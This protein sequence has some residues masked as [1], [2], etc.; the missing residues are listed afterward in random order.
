MVTDL[1]LDLIPYG[2]CPV[3]PATLYF[4][5]HFDMLDGNTAW[6]LPCP[7]TSDSLEGN[8]FLNP[9]SG[10]EMGWG[11]YISFTPCCVPT[12]TAGCDPDSCA[13]GGSDPP[14]D[15]DKVIELLACG[16]LCDDGTEVILSEE[17][18]CPAPAPG[19]ERRRG[20]GQS[21]TLF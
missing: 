14:T 3:D 9:K 21:W 15:P 18:L 4:A 12:G 8:P 1:I 6:A 10:K 5:I 16:S 13:G 20:L 2:N 17:V 19:P 7:E 11:Q